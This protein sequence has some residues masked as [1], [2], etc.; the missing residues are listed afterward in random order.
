MKRILML[1]LTS[2]CFMIATPEY[3]VTVF[4]C[5]NFGKQE[6]MTP[7]LPLNQDLAYKFNS[8]THE[9][10]YMLN[11]KLLSILNNK[12]NL[13]YLINRQEPSPATSH[14]AY[15]TIEVDT[16]SRQ[17]IPCL[18]DTDNAQLYV[19]INSTPKE[20]SSCVIQ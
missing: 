6:L 4:F 5:K 19:L 8:N 17:E 1:L 16:D 11:I 20:S 9:Y 10:K 2:S 3:D 13:E 15:R 12:A 18:L 7:N 14:K